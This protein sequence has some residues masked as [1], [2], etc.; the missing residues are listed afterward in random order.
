[1]KEKQTRACGSRSKRRGCRTRPGHAR[2]P[3]LGWKKRNCDETRAQQQQR[4]ATRLCD[5]KPAIA[6]AR[7]LALRFMGVLINHDSEVLEQRQFQASR[8]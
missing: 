1:M 3:L 7:K 5:L 6:T 8:C 4:F 2:R